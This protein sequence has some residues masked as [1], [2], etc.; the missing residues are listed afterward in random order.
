MPESPIQGVVLS[1]FTRWIVDLT[2][3]VFEPPFGGSP[4]IGFRYVC[5]IGL[6]IDDR[7]GG[8]IDLIHSPSCIVAA[9]RSDG[10]T[11]I[12]HHEGHGIIDIGGVAQTGCGVVRRGSIIVVHHELIFVSM[13]KEDASNGGG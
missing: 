11:Y 4:R 13:T 7:K 2:S 1:P 8:G 12:S 10:R 3:I 6:I 5:I 9:E